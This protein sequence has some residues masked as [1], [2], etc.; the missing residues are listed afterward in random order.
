M[1]YSDVIPAEF[2]RR[3]NR[4]VAVVLVNGV[5]ETVH[6]K[7]TGRC[8]ELLVPGCTVYLSK[9][10]NASRKTKYDLITVEKKRGNKPPLL[11]NIDSLAPNYAVGEWLL[12][13]GLFSDNSVIR[14]EVFYGKS[15]FDF[16]IDDNGSKTYL[17]VKGVTLE[18]NSIA[19]FPDAP[20]ERGV[21]HVN[22][23]A[24][25]VGNG[26]RGI[27]VFVIQMEDVNIFRPND[28]THPEFGEALRKANRAGVEILAV[29]CLVTADS[30]TI[31]SVIPVEL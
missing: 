29:N 26:H 18:N 9:S 15:R 27:I 13:S 21:K 5:P 6:V 3:I 31:D 19:A 4:F 25:C 17:E 30:M 24:E 20:T 10:S 14:R 22:E 8:L 2:V 12:K 16:F 1:E 7:N 23:L 28:E 11:V